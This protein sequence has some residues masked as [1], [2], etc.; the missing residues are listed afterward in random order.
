MEITL[1]GGPLDGHC[2]TIT[3][4]QMRR[5]SIEFPQSPTIVMLERPA[6]FAEQPV[7]S[8]VRYVRDLVD[9][10]GRRWVHQ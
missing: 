6:P 3:P 10:T 7:L 8:N 9:P 2:L 1:H 5:G 4:E